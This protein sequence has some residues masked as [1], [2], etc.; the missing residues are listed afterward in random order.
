M[1]EGDTITMGADMFVMY[2]WIV[3]ELRRD[4]PVSQSMAS[5][6]DQCEAIRPHADWTKLRMLDY[7][8][9]APVV[10]WIRATFRN[11]PPGY[12]MRG[13]WVGLCNPV[14]PD[15]TAVADM[16]LDGSSSFDPTPHNGRWAQECDWFPNDDFARSAVLAQIYRIAYGDE[17]PND[18]V[19]RNDVEYPVCLGYGAF[20]VRDALRLIDPAELL[21]ESTSLGIAVGFDSG[22]FVLLGR[23]VATGLVPLD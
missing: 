3:E 11:D 15:G 2:D 23:L 12:E 17:S 22:D 1:S 14:M 9:V 21:G 6:I 7:A 5:L 19:L 4:R 8:N 13:L 20:A 16:H 18:D 10:D